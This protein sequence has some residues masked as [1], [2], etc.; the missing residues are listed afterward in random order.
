MKC[1]FYEMYKDLFVFLEGKNVL[2]CNFSPA[3]VVD[4]YNKREQE[5]KHLETEL[6]EKTN[7]L[8]TYRQNIS[9]VHYHVPLSLLSQLLFV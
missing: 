7:A 5:I 6:E 4:E 1:L 3:K 9:E 2:L 8:S